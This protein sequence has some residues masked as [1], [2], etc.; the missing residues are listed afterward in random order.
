MNLLLPHTGGSISNAPHLPPLQGLTPPDSRYTLHSQSNGP[1]QIHPSHSSSLPGPPPRAGSPNYPP[2]SMSVHSA[3]NSS[4]SHGTGQHGSVD[5]TNP[6]GGQHDR[7]WAFVDGL[8]N[9]VGRL[10]EEVALLRGQVG[11]QPQQR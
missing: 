7:L 11:T 10:E 3:N 4:S 5:R 6:Y 1:G 9:K 8:A 2:G